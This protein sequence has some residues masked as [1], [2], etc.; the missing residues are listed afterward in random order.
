MGRIIN[1]LQQMN[2]IEQTKSHSVTFCLN[3]SLLGVVQDTYT[4]KTPSDKMNAIA[5]R[6]IA[7]I[8]LLTLTVTT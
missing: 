4:Q 6:I 3:R 2:I 8:A 5:H 1:E 7:L